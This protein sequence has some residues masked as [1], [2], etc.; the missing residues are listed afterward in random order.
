MGDERAA[1]WRVGMRERIGAR[2]STADLAAMLGLDEEEIERRRAA[3]ALAPKPTGPSWGARLGVV[4]FAF[5]LG[6]GVAAIGRIRTPEE[7]E[8]EPIR[9]QGGISADWFVLVTTPQSGTRLVPS[10]NPDLLARDLWRYRG[11]GGNVRVVWSGGDIVLAT[12]APDYGERAEALAERIARGDRGP[13][14]PIRAVAQ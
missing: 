2:P 3:L 11:R 6:G 7:V 4:A 12:D 10:S 13:G 1:A 9:R 8:A 14:G 5:V